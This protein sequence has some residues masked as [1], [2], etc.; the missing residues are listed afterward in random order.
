LT[1]SPE[2]TVQIKRVRVA[3]D[4]PLPAYMTDGAA[5]MA[6]CAD[7]EGEMVI[8]PLGRVLVPT[9]IAVSVPP[10]FEIQIR[11]RSGLALRSGITLLNSPG[12]I[13]S[14][15]RGEICLVVINL[16]G[17]PFR[18]VRGQRLAQMVVSS[19]VRARWN[20]VDELPATRRGTGGF[21]HTGVGD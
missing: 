20:E 21:G 5:G 9:G 6:L 14:D 7:I 18:V 2:I 12:T 4:I 15:Y 11:P 8:A 16:G 13:D 19:V 3:R 10:G 17:E 1:V